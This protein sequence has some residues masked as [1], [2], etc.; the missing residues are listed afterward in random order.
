MIIIR[1]KPYEHQHNVKGVQI[2]NPLLPA[3]AI[4]C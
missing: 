3:A 2:N 1:F 4:K